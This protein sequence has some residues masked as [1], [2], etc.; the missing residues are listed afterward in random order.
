M[1]SAPDADRRNALLKIGAVCAI[2][3]TLG[4]LVLFLVHGD[5]PDQTAESALSWVAQRPFSLL[6]LGIIL[7]S[8]LWVAAFLG[9]AA[10]LAD[11]VPWALGQLGSAAAIVGATL[12]AV[13]YRIDGPALEEVAD[14]WV[15]ATG[16]EKARLL[17]HG[18]LVLLMTGGGFP[19]YVALLLGLPFALFGI[20]VAVSSE[21]PSILGW[22]GAVVG[23]VGFSTGAANFALLA[24]IPIQLFVP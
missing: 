23:V 5:L 2:V 24:L 11:A 1:G 13:H 10:S 8:L 4:Y 18:E 15:V 22:L 17:E 21:Y 7:C 16:P 20:A 14:A 12:L 3:G 9:L 6:H 19:L